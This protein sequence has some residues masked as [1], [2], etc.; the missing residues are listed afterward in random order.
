[1]TFLRLFQNADEL[2]P[3]ATY[4]GIVASA[5]GEDGDG[6]LEGRNPVNEKADLPLP[7]SSPA[8]NSGKVESVCFFVSKRAG[9]DETID[10]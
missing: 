2:E 6:G 10:V 9:A 5:I 8:S 1:V 3:Y 4:E 7:A